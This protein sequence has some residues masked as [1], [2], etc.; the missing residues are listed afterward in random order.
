MNYLADAAS[1][2]R[3]EVK[4]RLSVNM[5]EGFVANGFTQHVIIQCYKI[6]Q[7]SCIWCVAGTKK[8]ASQVS[9][10]GRKKAPPVIKL[11]KI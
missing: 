6:L 4:K 7:F 2:L 8:G 9:N 10:A 5:T 3:G 11:N 1:V